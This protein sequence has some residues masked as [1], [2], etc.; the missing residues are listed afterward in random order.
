LRTIPKSDSQAD[1]NAAIALLKKIR[2]YPLSKTGNPPAQRFIDVSG[3]LWDGYPRI[4]ASFYPVLA[5]MVNEEPVL[6]RDLAI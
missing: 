2:M 5:K 1:Q 6:P 4:D 3:K